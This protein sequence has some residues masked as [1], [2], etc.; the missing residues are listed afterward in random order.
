MRTKVCLCLFTIIV[1]DEIMS[2]VVVTGGAGFVGFHLARVLVDHGHE[3][4]VVDD[5]STGSLDNVPAGAK[6]I[7][8]SILDD[9]TNVFR[10]VD[11]VFHLAAIASVPKSFKNPAKT[12]ETNFYGTA[13][14]LRM[15]RNCGVEKVILASS[16]SVYGN[17]ESDVQSEDTL[18]SPMSPYAKSKSDAEGLCDSYR[19][20]FG[21]HIVTLRYFNVYGEGQSMESGYALA[22]PAFI[23]NAKAGLPLTIYGNGEQE[24]DF[25]F[26][27]DVVNATIY[28]SVSNMMGIYNVGTGVSTSVNTLASTILR[29]SLSNSLIEYTAARQGDPRCTRADISKL[30]DAGFAP[31]WKLKEGLKRLIDAAGRI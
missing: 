13:A 28:A 9:I 22:V 7:R 14:V 10:D 11:C 6:F 26:I 24:R 20:L 27:D 1:K 29:L 30:V 31:S 15:A 12:I 2:K 17:S 19:K 4:I 3:V 21:M 25:I 23:K 18:L 16:S 8:A 5:L